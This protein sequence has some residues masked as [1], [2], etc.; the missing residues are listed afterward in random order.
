MDERREERLVATIFGRVQ[1]VGYRYFAEREANRL[2]L[3]GYVRNRPDNSVEVVAEGDRHILD[4]FLVLL[5]RGPSG[6]NVADIKSSFVPATGEF[7][8]FSVRRWY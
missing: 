2:G 4:G 7:Y 8:D 1:G 3:T 5:R 6:A